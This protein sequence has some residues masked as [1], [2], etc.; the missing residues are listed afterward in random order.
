MKRGRIDTH[1]LESSLLK[2][3][4][5]DDPIERELVIA[6]PPGYDE[7]PER[8]YPVV[9]CLSGFTGAGY[10]MLNRSAWAPSL[11]ERHDRLLAAGEIEPMILVMPDC[12]TRLGGSQYLD[13]A[14]TGRWESHLLLEL[15]P[16]VEAH[17]RTRPAP[18]GWGVMGKSSGGYGAI[19]QGMKHPD[20]F[21]AIACHSG[22]MYFEYCYLPD[23]PKTL[24]TV[25][26]KGGL[27]RFLQWFEASP[28]K[29]TE[30]MTALNVI[31][32]AS[33]YS[34]KEP[35]PGPKDPDLGIEFPFEWGTGELKAETWGRWLEHDP[36]RIYPRY[37]E[38]LSAMKLVF[39]DC[40]LRDEFH[41]QFG[42]R[43]LRDRLRQAGLAVAHE[44]FD[45]GHMNI[46]Y[47][48]DR[49]LGLL[50]AALGR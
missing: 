16:F 31:A 29:S 33:C 5:L 22:D 6:L 1:F 36:V 15:L 37:L 9:V 2:G 14:A 41:L 47:R 39:L 44:E 28:K 17:Y 13:S 46:A 7:E 34:P 40:G 32:M 50:S 21:S 4:P 11:P 25:E 38:A 12:F 26:A 19:V 18:D 45:D 27:L 20:R 10:M 35:Y 42:A 3:N 49:S 8:R 30:G 43:M 24:R 48:F 23:F